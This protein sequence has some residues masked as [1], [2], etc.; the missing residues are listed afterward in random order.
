MLD[1]TQIYIPFDYEKMYNKFSCFGIIERIKMSL[2]E[3]EKYFHA[4]VTFA[5]SE[6]AFA[7]LHYLKDTETNFCKKSKVMSVGNLDDDV[8]DFIPPQSVPDEEK[9]V[10]VL[11]LPTW[12]VA[13]YKEGKANMIKGAESIQRKVGNIPRGNLKRY[14]N[15]LLIKAGNKTQAALLSRYQPS[16]EGNIE[17]VSPHKSFNTKKGIIYSREVYEFCEQEIL[18]KCPAYVFKVQKLKNNNADKPN[19]AIL[20]TFTSDFI[21]DHIFIDHTRIKVKKFYR[22]PTQCFN[23]FEFGHGVDKCR[24]SKRCSRCSGEHD[25][26]VNCTNSPFCFLCE[27]SHSPKSRDCPRFKFEQE[28]LEVANSHYVSIGNAKGIVMGANKSPN[29]SY[30]K[31]IK[32]LKL[33]SFRPR[34]E[35]PATKASELGHQKEPPTPKA[36]ESVPQNEPPTPNAPE[37]APQEEP[38]TPKA[39]EMKSRSSHNHPS[40]AKPRSSKTSEPRERHHPVKS[41]INADKEK[42]SKREKNANKSEG[43]SKKSSRDDSDSNDGFIPT[44]RIKSHRSSEN[45]PMA[46]EVSNSF[47]VLASLEGQSDIA[48]ERVQKPQRTRSVEDIPSSLSQSEG[49]S[50]NASKTTSTCTLPKPTFPPGSR[51]K[52]LNFNNALQCQ[53]SGKVAPAGKQDKSS[54]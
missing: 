25:M 39:P 38:P 53:S 5:Q 20:L 50:L 33:N 28:V 51:V 31:V 17:S 48:V 19:N 52:L 34:R 2:T 46:V 30:A 22:R 45:V 15:S 36:P 11:P 16:L 10:R 26:T 3:N 42:T 41:A 18:D 44:K 47:S 37:S 35:V 21:P 32:A 27:G 7:A 4:Y 49:I 12:H 24:N 23:C 1:C 29:S 14:G 40:G 54:F 43:S 9:I 8:F 13:K 6:D